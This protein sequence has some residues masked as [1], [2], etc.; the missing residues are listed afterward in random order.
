MQYSKFGVIL[1]VTLILAAATASAQDAVDAQQ[2]IDIQ[3]VNAKAEDAKGKANGLEQRVTALESLPTVDPSIDGRVSVLET[4][5][6]D[7]GARITALE[8]NPG[9]VTQSDHDALASRVTALEASPDPSGWSM[10]DSSG[11]LIGTWSN[12]LHVGRALIPINGTHVFAQFDRDAISYLGIVEPMSLRFLDK[13]CTVPF[14][15]VDEF[16]PLVERSTEFF[17][18][19]IHATLINGDAHRLVETIISQIGQTE[20]Y[21]LDSRRRCDTGPG[22]SQ[23]DVYRFENL[24][25]LPTFYPPFTIAQE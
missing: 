6:G 11:A 23:T 1:F 24:G 25:P 20:T 16:V 10:Y 12:R 3:T 2:D 8:A 9:G 7:H 22:M 4:S 13:F 14:V 18:G 15:K 19:K 5:N 17:G 21:F